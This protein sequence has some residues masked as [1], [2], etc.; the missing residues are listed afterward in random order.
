MVTTTPLLL[1]ML[2]TIIVGVSAGILAWRERPE[3]G[4]RPLA[5]ML[6]GQSWW[7]VFYVFQLQ[8]T[9]LPQKVFWSNVE[10]LGVVVIPVAWLMF[11]LEY[12]GNDQYVRPRYVAALSVVPAVTVGLALFGDPQNLLFLD[13]YQVQANGASFLQQVPG[14]WWW[15]IAAYTY[16][17]GL[18]G[19]IP[20]LRLI[21]SDSQSFRA[22]SAALLLGTLAPWASNAL[23]LVGAPPFDVIDPTPIAF[24]VSGVAYL[25]ALTRFRLFGT[26]PA[27]MAN[28]RRLVFER[29][30]DGSVVVDSHDVVVDL[31]DNAAEIL[32]LEP[33]AAL[34]RPASEVIP[35]Y[36]GLPA[37]GQSPEHL[38]ISGETTDRYY[39]A[40]VTRIEDY[41]GRTIG[42]VITLH[43]VG[44][45]LRQ[46][47][48]LEVLNRVLRHN[49]RTETNLIS[50][51]AELVEEGNTEM[52][53]DIK[54]HAQ[55]IDEMGEKAR[56]IAEL[57]EGQGV[58]EEAVALDDLVAECLAE[59]ERE[60]PDVELES[61]PVPDGVRVDA[62]VRPVLANV[63]ENAAQHN[64]RSDAFVRVDVEVR[65]GSVHIVVEDNGPGITDYEQSVIERGTETPLEHGS[66]LGL[67]LVKWGVGIAGGT[68]HF[69][70]TE[71]S[72]M[73]VTLDVPR[74]GPDRPE[75]PEDATAV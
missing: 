13:A 28:A 1:V 5:L 3:P 50:G 26:S 19:T 64:P 42:R 33:R 38:T 7:S 17:L 12:T 8:A 2:L 57:F 20:L 35:G 16:L 43:D 71:P 46:Q 36:E 52:T 56:E 18:L 23:F 25:G 9:T 29:M 61:G 54:N 30:H 62:V 67:W 72:G 37:D 41:H 47:Q 70:E 4:A 53:A 48:R 75:E 22:Q 34:G 49:I 73:A 10:W 68:V 32:S 58:S 63:L 55:R 51:Y 27:P 74:V 21:R 40:T 69:E 31:N 44:D 15:I 11:A 59:I 66:G 14:P 39:D 60:F 45:L 6:A 24:S 65:E